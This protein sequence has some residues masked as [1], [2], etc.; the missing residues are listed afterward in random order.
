MANEAAAKG[1]SVREVEQRVAAALAGS[2]DTARKKR[3]LDR[4]VARLQ[5][6]LAEK[7]GTRVQIKAR[8]KGKG[9]LVIDY[10]SLDDLDRLIRRLTR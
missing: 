9:S 3:T 1:L 2:G 5:E 7:L 8:P 4:D 6:N 10:A